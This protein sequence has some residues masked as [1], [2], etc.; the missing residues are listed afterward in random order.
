MTWGWRYWPA[1]V[2][3]TAW[4]VAG[5]LILT[6]ALAGPAAGART[7]G[8]AVLS[9]V[10]NADGTLARGIGAVSA[11]QTGVDGEYRVTFGRDVSGCAYT[12]TAGEA[13]AVGP[14]DAITLSA[15]P[16][17][18]SSGTVFLLEYDAILARDSYSSG[19]HLIVVCP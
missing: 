5:A 8:P 7:T 2:M 11:Q 15:A 1:L 19:F 16:D 3:G 6:A 9:A 14:D 12:A 10:V 18:A 13:T 17:A 4:A